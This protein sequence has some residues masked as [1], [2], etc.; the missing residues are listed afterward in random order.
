VILARALSA[1]DPGDLEL[2]FSRMGLPTKAA[3]YLLEK[4]PHFQ[5][6]LTGIGPSEGRFLKAQAE[7]EEMP[8]YTPGDVQRRPG[9][10]LVS[11]RRDQLGRLIAAAESAELAPLQNALRR[12]LEAPPPSPLRLGGRV[13]ELGRRTLVMGVLNVTPDSFADG[14]KYLD[15]ARAISHGVAMARAGADLLDIGGESTRPG[16]R[17]VAAVEEQERVLP[18]LRGLHQ[19]IDVPLSIDTTKASVAREAISAGAS[20]VN[21]VSGLTGDPRMADVVAQSGVACC[22]MHAQGPPD[23]MQADPRY[24][25]VVA[26]VF[27]LLD[28]AV[29]RAGKAGI[30]RERILLDPGIGFGKTLEHNLTLLRRLRDFRQIG[31]GILAGTSRKSSLGKLVGDKPPSERLPA[32]LGSVAAIAVLGGADVVRVHDVSEVSDA[33]AVADAIRRAKGGGTLFERP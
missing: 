7:E 9:V 19:S 3:E 10:A 20:L 31:C 15:A 5:V 27:E 6:L 24:S 12:L 22:L 2:G 32:T 17:T 33:L 11:G 8:R 29:M 14:G 18:V 23:T 21:D 13:L 28:G 4:L 25:D 16:A 26:E 1:D 30:P